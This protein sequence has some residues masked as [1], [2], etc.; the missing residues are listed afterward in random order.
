MSVV[1]Y[2]LLFGF[3]EPI[4]C[5]GFIAG[6]AMRGRALA[7]QED[8]GWW[9]YGVVPGAIA[10]CGGTLISAVDAF[11]QRLKSVLIDIADEAADFDAFKLGVEL[12]FRE[13]DADAEAQWQAAREK[14]RAGKLEYRD[15]PKDTS[16][17][18]PS[19]RV[20]LLDANARSNA[21][22]DEHSSLAA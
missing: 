1:Q 20:E 3:Q 8:E 12:F 9:I 18:K 13:K 15:L 7:E 22:A 19:I 6:V 10:E 2:P 5:N 21:L 16:P 17:G 11:R 4:L 14:V